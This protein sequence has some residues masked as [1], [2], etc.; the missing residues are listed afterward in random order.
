[1]FLLQFLNR[2]SKRAKGENI[3]I[4]P[5]SKSPP[6]QFGMIRCLFRYSADAGYMRFIVEIESAAPE[7]AGRDF[8]FCSLFAHLLGFSFGFGPASA[9][10]SPEGICSLLRQDGVKGSAD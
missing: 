9:C 6:P 3:Y 5:C 1:M 7:A 10:R 2:I 4:Y 8:P